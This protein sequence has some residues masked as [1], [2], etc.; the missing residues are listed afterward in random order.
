MITWEITI[1]I[2]VKICIHIQCLQL[3]YISQKKNIKIKYFVKKII[4]KFSL[5]LITQMMKITNKN[6]KNSNKVELFYH[7]E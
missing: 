7:F 6:K 2:S 5:S 1:Q 4:T 3:N